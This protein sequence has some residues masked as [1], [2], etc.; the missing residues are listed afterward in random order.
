MPN[1]LKRYANM[2][3]LYSLQVQM[4]LLKRNKGY[5]SNHHV[6]NR[7]IYVV[8][9]YLLQALQA[10]RFSEV[11]VNKTTTGRIRFMHVLGF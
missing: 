3:I 4:H 2:A 5:I 7:N 11:S 1:A 9:S 10:A 8:Y 6:E